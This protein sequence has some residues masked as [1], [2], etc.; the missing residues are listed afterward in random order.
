MCI[1]N[2]THYTV[3]E[4]IPYISC[5]RLMS[6]KKIHVISW[7]R[8]FFFTTG[9]TEITRKWAGSDAEVQSPEENVDERMGGRGYQWGGDQLLISASHPRLNIQTLWHQAINPAP[10]FPTPLAPGFLTIPKA[11]W[12]TAPV[13]YGL[14]HHLHQGLQLLNFLLQCAMVFLP[15]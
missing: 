11:L 8:F 4:K 6:W 5:L 12:S 1:E 15:L 2:I 13:R 3:L 10:G 9:D 7:T 14:L